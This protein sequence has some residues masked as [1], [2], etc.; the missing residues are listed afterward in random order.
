MPIVRNGPRSRSGLGSSSGY[1]RSHS[2]TMFSRSPSRFTRSRL[3]RNCGSCGGSRSRRAL[4]RS[5]NESMT[6]RS[7]NTGRI[8]QW[9]AAG[10][11]YTMVA[12]PIGGSSFSTVMS[13]MVRECSGSFSRRYRANPAP[14]QH[15]IS[16]DEA[17][18]GTF[19]CCGR[20]TSTQ[21]AGGW[22]AVRPR[23]SEW[24]PTGWHE[25]IAPP[26]PLTP[27]S[28]PMALAWK[29]PSASVKAV[30]CRNPA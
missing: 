9:G 2:T 11:R 25:G 4:T 24:T 8:S 10:P 19:P 29:S 26:N 17:F 15:T 28:P 18:T 13:L 3:R 27:S 12:W 23:R 5:R 22:T 20:T 21:H 6:S 16:N 7:P 1:P 14:D 30:L